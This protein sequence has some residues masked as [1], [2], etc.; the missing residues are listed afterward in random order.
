MCDKNE[1]FEDST[2]WMLQYFM[3]SSI[4]SQDWDKLHHRVHPE[5]RKKN[6]RT[7]PEVVLCLS[8]NHVSH[9]SIAESN[10][11]LTRYTQPSIKPAHCGSAGYQFAQMRR[12]L[13]LVHL[14]RI[15]ERRLSRFSPPKHAVV[16]GYAS[17]VY[18]LRPGPSRDVTTR[19]VKKSMIVSKTFPAILKIEKPPW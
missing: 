19:A 15:L 12:G 6:L 7:H 8:Q 14:M 16:L 2:M 1:S 17:R 11:T 13:S 18:P 9:D 4:R 10:A 5:C 3:N